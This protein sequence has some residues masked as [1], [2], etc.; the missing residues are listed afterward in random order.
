VP[1][2]SIDNS[3]RVSLQEF[4]INGNGPNAKTEVI[5][6]TFS[7][8]AFSGNTVQGGANGV[9][10]VSGARASLNGDVLQN[11]VSGAG[12]FVGQNTLVQAIGVTTQSNEQGASVGGGFLQINSSK[13]QNNGGDGIVVSLGGTANL[14]TSTITGNRG[15]GISVVGHST[16]QLGFAGN[17]NGGPGSSVTNNS[18]VGILVKDLSFANFPGGVTNVVSGNEGGK[19]V[20]CSPQFPATRG[21]LTNFGGGTTNCTEP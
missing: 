3:T 12:I 17:G 9:D 7:Y 18:G 8:C 5:E 11:N 4:I 10:I 13:V 21:A 15:N 16:I 2:I 6:C 1:A 20:I 14:S 19:D